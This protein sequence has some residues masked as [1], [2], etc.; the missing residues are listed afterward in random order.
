ML[1]LT[2]PIDT[3]RRIRRPL[4]RDDSPLEREEYPHYDA[5]PGSSAR[6]RLLQI[7]RPQRNVILR[8]SRSPRPIY[9]SCP[10]GPSSRLRHR[11]TSRDRHP[12]RSLPNLEC[13]TG[14]WS[15]Q[16]SRPTK[17][18]RQ[19]RPGHRWRYAS[20]SLPPHSLPCPSYID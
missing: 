10:H 3:R 15:M 13:K 8:I 14:I 19:R 7:Q 11:E 18:T 6:H 2:T 1:L 9:S 16:S 17:V 20:H 12:C 5:L 4:Q